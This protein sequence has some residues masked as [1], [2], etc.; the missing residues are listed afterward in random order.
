M[1]CDP[2]REHRFR[3]CHTVYSVHLSM[4]DI[5]D[6]PT[7][8]RRVRVQRRLRRALTLR[9][10]SMACNLLVPAHIRATTRRYRKVRHTKITL[11]HAIVRQLCYPCNISPPIVVKLAFS[12]R[13]HF[14]NGGFAISYPESDASRE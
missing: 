10:L 4:G 1:M 2:V 7:L 13:R 3:S 8:R 11:G 6:H 5:L 9:Q 14:F 12:L